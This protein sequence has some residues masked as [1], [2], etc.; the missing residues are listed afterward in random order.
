MTAQRRKILGFDD[1]GKQEVDD[2]ILDDYLFRSSEYE[3]QLED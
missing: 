2:P 3:K 1:K